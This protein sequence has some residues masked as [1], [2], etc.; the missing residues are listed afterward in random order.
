MLNSDRIE[1]ENSANIVCETEDATTLR[2]ATQQEADVT[3]FECLKQNVKVVAYCCA[4]SVGPI[5][6]GF[7]IIIVALIVAMPAFQEVVRELIPTCR[8]TTATTLPEKKSS[9]V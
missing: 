5:V 6:Y 2:A 7:D 3:I 1:K 4:I 8:D 9:V